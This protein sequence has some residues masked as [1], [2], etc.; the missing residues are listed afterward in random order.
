MSRWLDVS[1][2]LASMEECYQTTLPFVA[3]M[4]EKIEFQTEHSP[5]I[6]HLIWK[7]SVHHSF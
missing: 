6:F 1:S 2:V 3:V 7:Y 4:E 5:L